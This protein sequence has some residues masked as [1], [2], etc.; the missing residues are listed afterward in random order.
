MYLDGILSTFYP[1]QA[2]GLLLDDSAVNLRVGNW[3][4]GTT[5]TFDGIIDSVRIYSKNLTPD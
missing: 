1:E 4:E 2:T 3:A 5:R